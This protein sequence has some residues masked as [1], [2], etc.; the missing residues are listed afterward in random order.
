MNAAPREKHS[1]GKSAASPGHRAATKCPSSPTRPR[2]S[3]P[4]GLDM[5]LKHP[6]AGGVKVLEPSQ[7]RFIRIDLPEGLVVNTGAADGLAVCSPKQV[8]FEER[9]ASHCPD[10][11]KLAATELDIPVLERKLLGAIYLREPEP[12]EPWRVWV[13][14]DD[15]GLHVKFPGE[16]ELDK[17]T[18]QVHSIIFGTPQTEGIP[19]APLREMK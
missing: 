11:S 13:V 14:A 10:A 19:Q 2:T 18:G 17:K 4:T 6:A 9:T 12:A 15:L 3:A 1:S 16:L 5:T 7:T 8:G